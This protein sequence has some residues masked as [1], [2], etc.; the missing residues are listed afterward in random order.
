MKPPPVRG[1]PQLWR[2]NENYNT[3]IASSFSPFNFSAN[4]HIIFN[5]T[6]RRKKEILK[7]AGKYMG[8]GHI[9]NNFTVFVLSYHFFIP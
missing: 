2:Q 4:D 6:S 9:I 1:F 3:S 8:F 5:T 7:V